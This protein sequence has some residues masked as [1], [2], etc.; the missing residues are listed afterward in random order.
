MKVKVVKRKNTLFARNLPTFV[1]KLKVSRLFVTKTVTVVTIVTK[2][3]F[4]LKTFKNEM[5][6]AT[7][8]GN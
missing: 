4:H 6:R 3:P 5:K 7:Q 2:I 1:N 8:E